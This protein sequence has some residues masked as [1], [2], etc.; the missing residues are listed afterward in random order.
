MFRIFDGNF[1]RSC[2]YYLL[3]ELQQI[4]VPRIQDLT[5]MTHI[6]DTVQGPVLFERTR[7]LEAE[8]DL[9]HQINVLNLLFWR[10]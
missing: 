10:Y 8:S 6:L 1:L 7:L 5:K 4:T 9:H 2:S 3:L